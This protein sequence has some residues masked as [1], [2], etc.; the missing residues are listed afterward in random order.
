MVKVELIDMDG[1]KRLKF[2]SN[3]GESDLLDS[4]GNVILSSDIKR[5]SFDS[6]GSMMIDVKEDTSGEE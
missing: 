3:N 2:T 5:G 4:I 6:F 1:F